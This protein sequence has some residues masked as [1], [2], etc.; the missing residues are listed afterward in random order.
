MRADLYLFTKGL[1]KSRQ[2]AK[3]LIEDGNVSIDGKIINKPSFDLDE[4]TSYDT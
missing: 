2:K 4:G 3:T 1:V